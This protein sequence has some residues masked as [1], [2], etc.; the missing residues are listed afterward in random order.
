MMFVLNLMTTIW[1]TDP[2]YG[3]LSDYEGYKG[4]QEY[5]GCYVFK[6][7]PHKKN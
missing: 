3:I 2:P 5:G 7:D 6:F 1:F 4:E